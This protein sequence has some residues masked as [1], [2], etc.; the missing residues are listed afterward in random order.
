MNFKSFM[1]G[2]IAASLI[3]IFVS[4][5]AQWAERQSCKNMIKMLVPYQYCLKDSRCNKDNHFYIEY[6]KI[7]WRIERCENEGEL[8]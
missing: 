6:W 4:Y 2:V 8:D 7:R 1:S 3:S 5:G